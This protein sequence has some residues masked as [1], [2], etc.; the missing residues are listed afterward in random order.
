MT[1]KTE[2]TFEEQEQRVKE[3]SWR[4]C[5]GQ[6]G[7]VVS[8]LNC[9]SDGFKLLSSF[10]YEKNKQTVQLLYLCR[11]FNSLRSSYE[12]AQIGYYSQAVMLLRSVLEDL[13]VC[14]RCERD[15]NMVKRLLEGRE[16]RFNFGDMAKSQGVKFANW[17]NT[18][19]SDLSLFT[20]P[21]SPGLRI[22]VSPV[23][24]ALRLGPGFD[25]DLLLANVY[26]QLEILI[27]LLRL[28]S[29]IL[30]SKDENIAKKW[31]IPSQPGMMQAV[32]LINEIAEQLEPEGRLAMKEALASGE[33]TA[34]WEEYKEQR[35]A[36]VRKKEG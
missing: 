14:Y 26:F 23:E 29:P 21:R 34:S 30:R 36:R 9:L 31:A 28:F 16:E 13:L 4:E 20:H 18:T 11:S 6:L 27:R 12:L 2:P 19:Y 33:E 1:E 17:W 8:L 3:R 15:P 35:A 5:E 22:L 24:H 7:V 25:R 32:K 10:A